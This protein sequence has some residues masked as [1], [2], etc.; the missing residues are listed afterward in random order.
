M[1]KALKNSKYPV[2]I[3]TVVGKQINGTALTN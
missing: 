2:Y 1:Y 3:N